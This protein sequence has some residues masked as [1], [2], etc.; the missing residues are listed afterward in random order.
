MPEPLL[1]RIEEVARQLQV[2]RSMAYNLVQD[3][4]IPAVRFGRSVR[5]PQTALLDWVHQQTASAMGAA[6]VEAASAGGSGHIDVLFDKAGFDQL[7]DRF[8]IQQAAPA[9]K[10]IASLLKGASTLD[11]RVAKE[12]CIRRFTAAG[13]RTPVLMIDAAFR[14]RRKTSRT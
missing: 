3:G 8:T 12:E 6:G 7:G 1:L 14:E 4:R 11:R 13:V 10:R 2:S 9:L 5:V